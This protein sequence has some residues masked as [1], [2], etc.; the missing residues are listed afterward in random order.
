MTA[1][2]R[3][4]GSSQAASFGPTKNREV[5]EKLLAGRKV[6]YGDSHPWGPWRLQE[7]EITE[8]RDVTGTLFDATERTFAA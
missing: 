1:E 3:V 8:W 2:Y 4:V 7:R 5:A 6:Q